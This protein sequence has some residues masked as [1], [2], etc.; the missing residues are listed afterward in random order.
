MISLQRAFAAVAVAGLLL[1]GCGK[2]GAESRPPDDGY[3]R[4]P[5]TDNPV[6]LDPALFTD[7]NSEGVARRIFN[8][9]VK[10]DSKLQPVPDLAESW[11]VSDDGLTYTFTLR[12]GVRFHNGREMVADDVRF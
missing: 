11:K 10:L 6:T 9:L 7:V 5:L 4:L 12:K 1:A 8:N 2:R 3:Y